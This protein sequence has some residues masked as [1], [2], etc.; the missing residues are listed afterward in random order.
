MALGQ[1]KKAELLG[2]IPLFSNMNKRQL[3]KIAKVAYEYP[4]PVEAGKEIAR[5][6]D[7]GRE[8]YVILKGTARVKQ[9][10]RTIGKLS[11]GDYFGEIS[12]LDG[13]VRSA[14]VIADSDVY[15]M[16]I[17]S[18]SFKQLLDSV[19]GLAKKLV[20][21]LCD[22]LRNAEKKVSKLS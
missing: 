21:A 19:P 12:L 2:K 3:N 5:E 15:L 14:S 11:K 13:R 1:S 8:F 7:P 17:S 20:F 9:K 22:Y 10:N 6:G 16:G 18:T 4:L